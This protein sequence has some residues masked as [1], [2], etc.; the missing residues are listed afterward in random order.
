MDTAGAMS[1]ENVEVFKLGID[2]FNRRDLDACLE[3]ADPEVEGVPLLVQMEGSYRGHDGMRR[4]WEDLLGVF[5][6][7]TVEVAEVRDL[8]DVTLGRLCYRARA[9]E[10]D[11]P[12]EAQVWMAVRWRRG[13]WVWWRTFASQAD[14]LEA[15][16]LRE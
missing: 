12:V 11:T 16:A 14:A 5:P 15:V 4:W 8:A 9:A 3:L 13:K 7:F 6:D 10:S 1:Q 2:A